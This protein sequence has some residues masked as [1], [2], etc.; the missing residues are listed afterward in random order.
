MRLTLFVALLSVFSMT[1]QP[2]LAKTWLDWIFTPRTPDFERPYLQ[3]GKTPHNSQREND[4]WSP[5]DWETAT[6]S[7]EKP[8][9][10][11][12]NAGIVEDQVMRGNVPVL[13]VGYNFMRLS[14]LEK[15]HVMQYIDELFGATKSSAGM[16]LVEQKSSWWWPGSGTQ[17]GVYTARGLQLQ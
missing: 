8:M 3:D 13:K 5:L 7:K 17:V 9:R 4:E 6:G 11:L 2:V 16:I 1:A 14:D 10:D 15:N 12:Y